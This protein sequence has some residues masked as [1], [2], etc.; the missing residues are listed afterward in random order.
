M[1]LYDE[2]FKSVEGEAFARCVFSPRGGGYFEG[3]KALEE[4]SLEK[5]V[6]YFP[7]ERVEVTGENLSIGKYCEGDLRVDGKIHSLRVLEGE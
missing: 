7:K 3:V 1:R 2:I 6:L 5:I 4:F